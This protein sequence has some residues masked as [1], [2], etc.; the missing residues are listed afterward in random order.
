MTVGR[1]VSD[2]EKGDVLEPVE[3]V[4]SPFI[5]REYAHGVEE[6]AEVFQG[7]T[8]ETRQLAPPTLI[9]IDKI[10][11]LKRNCPLGRGPHAR[12]HYEY[13][14]THHAPIHVG[15]RLVALGT[16]TDRYEKRGRD[17]LEISI[18]LRRKKDNELLTSYLDTAVLSYESKGERE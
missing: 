10:R 15:E 12:I 4:L 2:L 8:E 11:L 1:Y 9:H 3:Y 18:E 14:A 16:V 17:Y 7:D 13:S 6:S 5:G